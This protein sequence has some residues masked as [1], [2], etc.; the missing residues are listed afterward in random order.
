MPRQA[1]PKSIQL[2]YFRELRGYLAVC[3]TAIQRFLLPQ[4]KAL[5]DSRGDSA[6]PS[7]LLARAD[8][9]GKKTRDLVQQ[10]RD[11]LSDAVSDDQLER[12]AKD[13]GTRT[14]DFQKQQLNKQ[15]RSALGVDLGALEPN[16]SGQL[17]DFVATNVSL[18]KS[19]SSKYFDQV[20]QVVLTGIR[21]GL[22]AEELATRLLERFD[23]AESSA[24]LIAR[25]QTLKLFGE[26]NQ[27]RQQELG[28]EGYLWRTSKD[29]RVR[30]THAERE[31][32]RF[33]WDDPPEDGH[34]GFPINCRCTA[35]PV[36]E[37]LLAGL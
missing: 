14:S 19:I 27:A 1:E 13:I 5:A 8:A 2:F 3:R 36:L 31:G 26:V 7:M 29:S 20:E 33:T 32:M 12:L 23:V 10:A 18:I 30:E 25:D 6:I 35:E 4:L 15:I 37:D 34:P 9:G 11:A 28:V 24:A 21:Q 17:E 22:R 16:I